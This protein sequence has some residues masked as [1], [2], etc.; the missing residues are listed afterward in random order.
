MPE[1]HLMIFVIEA[2]DKIDISVFR[3]NDRGAGV[4][5]ITRQ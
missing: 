5:N 2:V 3:V 1:N 4:S